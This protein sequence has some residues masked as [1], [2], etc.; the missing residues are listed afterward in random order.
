MQ[1]YARDA[2]REY[3]ELGTKDLSELK[4]FVKGLPKLLMLDRLTDIATPVAE[5]VCVGGAD[6]MKQLQV[7]GEYA[8]CVL[9]CESVAG[10]ALSFTDTPSTPP[11]LLP[12]HPFFPPQVKRQGFHDRLKQEFDVVEGYDT[13]A[14]VA[15]IEV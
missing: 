4:S 13:E 14:S 7:W 8:Q 5:Q 2:R 12:P 10:G 3:T 11:S 15:F 9:Q 1:R 6:G